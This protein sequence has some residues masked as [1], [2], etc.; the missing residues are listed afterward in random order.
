MLVSPNITHINSVFCFFNFRTL[1]TL[2]LLM[3]ENEGEEAGL[4][5]NGMTSIQ[6]SI[7]LVMKTQTYTH[8]YTDTT[9]PQ[10]PIV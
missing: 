5:F 6:I 1:S 8:T 3:V 7:T 2:L 10:F 9:M 4:T